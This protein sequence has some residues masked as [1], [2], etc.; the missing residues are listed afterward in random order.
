MDALGDAQALVTKNVLGANGEK[1]GQIRAIY[2]DRRTGA[3][4][5]AAVSLGGLFGGK[6]AFAPVAQVMRQG[7]TAVVVWDKKHLKSAPK[8]QTEGVMSPREEEQLRRYYGID[9]P[10][11][12]TSGCQELSPGLG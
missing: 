10:P 6:T 12:G 11:D 7:D 4:E 5:W 8:P 3:P 1:L 2:V 9:V